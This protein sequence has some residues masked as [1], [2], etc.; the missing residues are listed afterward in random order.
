MSAALGASCK[1]DKESLLLVDL[2]LAAGEPAV[3]GRSPSRWMRRRDRRRTTTCSRR[4]R[5]TAVNFGFYLPADITG[6]VMMVAT[7]FPE[8]GCAG[9]RGT[10]TVMVD[11][12]GVTQALAITMSAYDTCGTTGVGGTTGAS[13]SGGAGTGGGTA[14]TGTA[15]TG[16]SAGTGTAGAAGRGIPPDAVAP[17]AAGGSAGT[18][19]RRGRQPAPP[20]AVAPVAAAE[21]AA[22]RH[23]RDGRLPGDQ[24]VSD[25]VHCATS[26]PN[27]YVQGVA[28]S[29]QR[30]ARRVRRRRRTRSRSG[31]STAAR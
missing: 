24:R 21:P 5:P 14:G 19:R 18:G 3:T 28:I 2:K 9:F 4:C 31:T 1:K 12:A 23:G 29:P 20:D 27:T 7:A 15:G 22:R 17:A 8:T 10:G 11:A 26:C 16:G 30:P 13:G 6:E 25:Y